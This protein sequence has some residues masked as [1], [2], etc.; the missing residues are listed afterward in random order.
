MGY[1]LRL[2]V[3]EL[4]KGVFFEWKLGVPNPLPLETDEPE[5]HD[6]EPEA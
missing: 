6:P 5:T 1:S 2:V 4:S 3:Y